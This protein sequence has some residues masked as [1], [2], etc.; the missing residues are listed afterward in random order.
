M[1]SKAQEE[2][3]DLTPVINLIYSLSPCENRTLDL[4]SPEG[5][6]RTP[7]ES[8]DIPTIT[9][10][11]SEQATHLGNFDK[12]WQYLGQPVNQLPP[13]S[14]SVSEIGAAETLDLS[15]HGFVSSSKAVKWRDE[16][17]GADLAD[18]DENFDP[19]SLSSLTKAQRKKAR[20]RQRRE[21][22]TEA[23]TEG[24]PLTSDSEDDS[25]KDVKAPQTPD[26][27]AIIHEMLHGNSASESDCGRVL[28]A[29]HHIKETTTVSRSWPVASPHHAKSTV[30]TLEHQRDSAF[31]VAVAKKVKLLT[32]LNETFIDER[33]YL[34]NISFVQPV[35]SS[36]GVL[37]EGIHIFVDVSNVS[38]GLILVTQLPH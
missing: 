28:S 12:I 18:N 13:S 26:R 5:S 29:N 30:K 20:R 38:F 2:D 36:S 15:G 16:L 6:L 3:W 11:K 14:P 22:H 27:R 7:P 31:A 37:A 19:H 35:S 25:G 4:E 10:P 32:L 24:R 1:I 23:P 21:K 33:P 17:E 9:E 8:P 34:S